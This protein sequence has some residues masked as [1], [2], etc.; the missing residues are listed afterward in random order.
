LSLSE[1][2]ADAVSYSFAAATFPMSHAAESETLEKSGLGDTFIGP[3]FRGLLDETKDFLE[4]PDSSVVL[5]SCLDRTFSQL[6]SSL[7]H[8]FVDDS[9]PPSQMRFEELQ[10]KKV[11]LAAVLPALARASH[12][13]LNTMPN[14]FAEALA[15]NRELQ[16]FSAVV[17]S[18]FLVEQ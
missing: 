5:R 1:D 13:I 18:N 2:D 9:Q 14:E 6:S 12:S 16:E 8:L 7:A 3:D 4:S 10:D 17:Y 15:D 11:R